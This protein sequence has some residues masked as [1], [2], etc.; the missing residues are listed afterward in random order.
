M[1]FAYLPQ[2]TIKKNQPEIADFVSRSNFKKIWTLNLYNQ[3]NK[4]F[5]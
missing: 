3:L 4:D 2:F 5:T 1:I